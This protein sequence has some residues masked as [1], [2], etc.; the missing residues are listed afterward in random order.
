MP[1]IWKHALA[2]VRRE[3]PAVLVV[4]V[5]CSGSVPGKTGAKMVVSELGCAGTIGGG[6]AE[7]QL[8]ERARA[9]HGGI[10]LLT[11][12]H[13][14]E[15]DSLCAGTQTFALIP[16]A[17][18]HTQVLEKILATLTG[19]GFGTLHLS[20]AGMTFV[21]E[22]RTPR[23]FAQRDARWSYEE[24]IGKL[25]TMYIIGGG[26]VSLALSRVMATL[27]FRIVVLDNREH[28]PTML[29]N[30]FAQETRVIDYA[31]VSDEI[32][33]DELTWVVIMTHGH[34]DD[35][36]VLECLLGRSFR[37]L[38]MM[39][40]PV[41][42]RQIFANIEGRGGRREL[43]DQV[44]APIGISIGSHTPEEIAISIAAEIIK[45]RNT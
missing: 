9:H 4:V 18:R 41:K 25:D 22:R 44:R 24:T 37:Y 30:T 42:I 21:S 43:L 45:L 35:E 26:H 11:F 39:G 3:L 5:D 31:R 17:T 19:D 13:T 34:R 16:L 23:K 38:G 40:S 8:I 33:D 28:L 1:Q 7:S 2:S 14:P 27:P 15:H 6:I 32:P 29:E 10:E 12:H 36:A 20:L